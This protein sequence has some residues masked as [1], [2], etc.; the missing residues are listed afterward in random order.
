MGV[1]YG[2][3]VASWTSQPVHPPYGCGLRKTVRTGWDSFN[4]FVG[5]W[6]LVWVIVDIQGSC[7]ISWFDMKRA[8]LYL[9]MF[10]LAAN[11]VAMLS[12]CIEIHNGEILWKSTFVRSAKD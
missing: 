1:K 8:F 2:E 10:Q 4:I 3:R 11:K 9:M 12:N 7:M 6:A 5:Y